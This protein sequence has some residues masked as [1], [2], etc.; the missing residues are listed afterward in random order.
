MFI[1]KTP[2][3]RL[4]ISK[5]LVVVLLMD[6]FAA[7]YLLSSRGLSAASMMFP[8]FLLAGI[9]VFS[10]LCI[11]QSVRFCREPRPETEGEPAGF[12]VTGKLAAF[13]LLVLA[14]LLSFNFLGAVLSLFLFL[15]LSMAI[16][17]IRSKLAL[18][19]V[20]A[21]MVSFVYLVFK[22]WLAVPL[23]AGVLT[24]LP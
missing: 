20:P 9:L 2:K 14:A 12:A 23:P 18:L 13:A 8:G 21:A 1:I 7:A 10:I 19:L 3:G 17:G 15:A 22:V 24:F 16:L 11:K 6:A 5:E 4:E